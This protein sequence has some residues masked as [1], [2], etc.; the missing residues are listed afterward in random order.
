[1][2]SK[3][4]DDRVIFSTKKRNMNIQTN[5]KGRLRNTSLSFKHGLMPLF[6][7]VVNSIQAIED[8]GQNNQNAKIIIEVIRSPQNLLKFSEKSGMQKEII[9]FK[10]ID[11]GV[12]F[13]EINMNSFEMLDSEHKA[14]K[15]CKGIGR[16]LWLK[17]FKKVEVESIYIFNGEKKLRK[18]IFDAEN[19]IVHLHHDVEKGN[20]LKTV[21]SLLNF[22][23]KYSNDSPQTLAL[24]SKSLLEHC[25]WY[26]VRKCGAPKIYI[27]DES[28]QI[29]L[30][31]LYEEYMHSSAELDKILIKGIEFDI[32]HLKFRLCSKKNH[33]IAYCATNRLV[34]EENLATRIPGLS[35]KISDDEG[36]FIYSCYLSSRYLDEKVCIER[37]SFNLAEDNE[38]LFS[39]TELSKKCIQNAVFPKIRDYLHSS[40]EAKIRAG[41]ERLDAFIN[42][43]A[44]RYRPILSHISENDLIIDPT[45]SDKELDLLLHRA[46]YDIEK[47]LLQDGHEI[48]VPQKH[49]KFKEYQERIRN[50]L[51]TANDIKQSDLANYVSHRRVILD[52]LEMAT[53]QHSNGKYERESLI[54]ELIMPLRTESN[55][56][57]LD[58]CN[59]W[60]IDERLAFH[61]YLASDKPLKTMPITGSE[62]FKEPDLCAL[63]IC[64][65]PILVSEG[66]QLPLASIVIVEIKRPM[67]NDARLSEDTD[68][69]KQVLEYLDMIR[70]GKICT[71]RGRPIPNSEN[72]PGYCYIVCDLTESVKKLC[73]TS[74]LTITSDSMGYFGYHKH[75]KA[76]IEVISFDRLIHAAKQRNK[77]FF[78]K[79]GLPTT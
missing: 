5:L 7:A 50:Y 42:N 8:L 64:D 26:F 12:G 71:H 77:A 39:K 28:E 53:H 22:D 76:Y 54:H 55:E 78:D 14:E 79:L 73:N 51:K 29:D 34:Q 75:Y 33:S 1:M 10:I 41:K 38:D 3:F 72:V 45:I 27:K 19:G 68:P 31:S 70:K 46:L 30:H 49:E 48:M 20:D 61:N 16:L 43:K 25:L 9:G 35:N 69:I 57:L 24:I 6:E 47:K 21:V 36:E 18:F 56:I 67:R 11:N 52:L 74:D 65:N 4:R 17:A 59:L 15:G 44:P 13:N 66:T 58:S 62:E 32:T 60:L 2:T 23:K 40:L 37:T 63:N